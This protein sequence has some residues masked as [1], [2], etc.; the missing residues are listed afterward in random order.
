MWSYNLCSLIEPIRY[1]VGFPGSPGG[2]ASGS[3]NFPPT[4]HQ[5]VLVLI[6]P[7]SLVRRRGSMAW[8]STRSEST[9][10]EAV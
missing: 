3:R 1:A 7:A 5:D 9:W 8:I 6:A 2:R 4:D 10:K